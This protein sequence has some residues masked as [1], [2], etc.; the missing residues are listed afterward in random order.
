LSGTTAVAGSINTSISQAGQGAA[1]VFLKPLTG[2]ANASQ[3]TQLI[4]SDASGVDAFGYSVAISG[5]TI[6]VGAPRL[7]AV[8]VFVKPTSGWPVLTTQKAKIIAPYGAIGF[9]SS[10]GISGNTIVVGA[11]YSGPNDQGLAYLFVKP[12]GGWTNTFGNYTAQLSPSDLGGTIDDN[13]GS[14]VSISLNTVVIGEPKGNNNAQPGAA[15]L[16]VKP[17]SGWTDMSETAELR[18]SNSVA[19][20]EFGFSVSVSAN[21]VVVGS[22]C[23]PVTVGCGPGA[24]YVFVEPLTGWVT[25][26]ETAELTASDGAD[27]NEFGESVSIS[28]NALAIGAPAAVT[29]ATKD[30]GAAYLY[31]KPLTGW[32]TTSKFKAKL[33]SSNGAP[34][35]SFGYSVAISYGTLAAGAP[36]QTVGSNVA[37][38]AVYIFGN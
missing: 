3:T 27:W 16:F 31:N 29:G 21:T 6:V 14:S 28:G 11:P 18:G 24:A 2:W 1:Y 20:D 9:G 30:Q 26:T 38:G 34:A 37:E 7:G 4:A 10:V 33:A 15:Y 35:D 25:G 8:Y 32:A 36:S 12:R 19:G 23:A 22:Y 17:A 5:N 13:F